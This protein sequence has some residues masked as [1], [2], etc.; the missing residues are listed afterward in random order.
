MI[1]LVVVGHLLT[2]DVRIPVVEQQIFPTAQPAFQQVMRGLVRAF[3]NTVLA[4]RIHGRGLQKPRV[5]VNA[6]L[7]Q[8]LRHDRVQV[9][10][11]LV[12]V[13]VRLIE[14][15]PGLQATVL[16]SGGGG[17][18]PD[19]TA[20]RQ[21]DTRLARIHATTGQQ[22]QRAFRAV[23]VHG[24]VHLAGLLLGGRQ[25]Y[26][27]WRLDRTAHRLARRIRVRLPEERIGFTALGPTGEPARAERLEQCKLGGETALVTPLG[28]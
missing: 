1:Q 17:R 5:R 23:V 21:Q 28:P 10:Q 3:G 15:T 24:V 25:A 22:A 11:P 13:L 16:A 26:D 7:R 27:Q 19:L 18:I 9:T 4:R 8:V 14:T 2:A 6:A 12:V 20:H